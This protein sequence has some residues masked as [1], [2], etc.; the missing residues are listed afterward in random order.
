MVKLLIHLLQLGIRHADAGVV[1]VDNQ[2][3]SIILPAVL[4][5]D[6]YAALLRELDRV[7]H[8]DLEHVGDLFRVAHQ[9]RRDLGVD[10][11]D[12]LQMLPV[13]LQRGHGDHVVEHR[14][15]HVL[16]LGRR[17]RALHDLRVVE[18][19]VDLVGQTLARQFDGQHILPNIPGECLS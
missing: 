15:D 7:L 11:E 12:Q 1:D 14:G 3:N 13:A 16:L 4:D 8:Q 2:V 10:I 18:H 5:T 9:D 6:V 19:I 17:Q